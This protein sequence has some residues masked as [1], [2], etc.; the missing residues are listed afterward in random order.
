LKNASSASNLAVGLQ[1][2]RRVDGQLDLNWN[3]KLPG[4]RNTRG[5]T[6]SILDGAASRVLELTPEQLQWG[7]LAYFPTSD[8]IQ[9]H[10]E[11][12]LDR[13]HSVGESIRVISPGASQ[14]HNPNTLPPLLEGLSSRRAPRA[15]SRQ[16]E[17][18]LKGST[19]APVPTEPITPMKETQAAKPQDQAPQS[20]GG[21]A[22]AAST[23]PVDQ[24]T[25]TNSASGAPTTEAAAVTQSAPP[26]QAAKD[27]EVK[28]VPPVVSTTHLI[29]AATTEAPAAQSLP[30]Q[31]VRV[32]GGQEVSRNTNPVPQV[33]TASQVAPTNGAGATHSPLG[34]SLTPIAPPVREQ[35]L[36]TSSRLTF[37]SEPEPL[38]KVLPNSRPF[39]YPL[40]QDAIEID[41]QVRID[42]KGRVVDARGTSSDRKRN[43]LLTDQAILAARRWKFKPAELHG[44]AIPSSY[45][46]KFHFKGTR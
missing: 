34:S 9:F 31:T 8:D 23:A 13:G 24:T 3:K 19:S 30:P 46:I 4:L 25:P 15:F 2:N 18:P 14:S 45:L 16:E 44:Q 32:E 39:G 1:V 41:V 29:P 43:S 5:A 40:A 33:L 37:S 20:S 12:A 21:G 42:E 36:N 10:L 38:T 35:E 7:T 28:V 22:P 26:P 6:L 17:I 27:A 11:I